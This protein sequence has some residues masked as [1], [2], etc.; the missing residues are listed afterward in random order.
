MATAQL[1]QPAKERGPHRRQ[2]VVRDGEPVGRDQLGE[3][4]DLQ[5]VGDRPEDFPRRR[6]DPGAGRPGDDTRAE[7]RATLRDLPAAAPLYEA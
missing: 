3:R 4:Q 7:V 2:R 1:E 5:L 6:G